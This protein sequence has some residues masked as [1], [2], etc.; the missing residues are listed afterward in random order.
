MRKKILLFILISEIL[1]TNV[2]AQTWDC[3]PDSSANTCSATLDENGNFTISGHGNMKQFGSQA[4]QVPWSSAN[5]RNVV[6]EDG[7]TN[8]GQYAFYGRTIE[9]MVVAPT[10]TSF[11]YG[12]LGGAQINVLISPPPNHTLNPYFR[13]VPGSIQNLYCI[14]DLTRCENIFL[15]AEQISTTQKKEKNGA[16]YIYD[17]NGQ[18]LAKYGKENPP[19]RIYT[20]E[21]ASRLSKPKGNTFKLRYK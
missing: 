12:S 14:G 21:E 10:V 18:F 11:D 16:T 5:I 20:V 6:I 9:T 15:T 19:K 17:S 3:S 8:I 13:Q 1:V 4:G 2:M 7:I